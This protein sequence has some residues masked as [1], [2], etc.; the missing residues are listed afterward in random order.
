MFCTFF[1]AI[2]ICPLDEIE[3]SHWIVIRYPN[4]APSLSHSH[5]S[6]VTAHELI[7]KY[8]Q[9]HYHH[10]LKI[11]NKRWLLTSL[12]SVLCS[13]TLNTVPPIVL[14]QKAQMPISQ[15]KNSIYRNIVENLLPYSHIDKLQN[16]L[17]DHPR[18]NDCGVLR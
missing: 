1:V 15:P 9:E 4:A 11:R 17:A 18:K 14:T 13:S 7:S 2:I 12:R 8:S 3:G 6:V 16:R 10:D 5:N